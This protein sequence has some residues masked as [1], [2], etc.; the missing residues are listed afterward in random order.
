MFEW[1]L[2]GI[3]LTGFYAFQVLIFKTPFQV[4][5]FINEKARD[6]RLDQI[7]GFAMIGIVMIHIHSYFYFFHPNEPNVTNWTLFLS[8]LS[9]FSVPVFVFGSSL[10]LKIKPGY[11]KTKFTGLVLPYTLASAIGYLI[12]YKDWA[13]LDFTLKLLTGQVFAPYYFVPL[14]FQFYILF[15]ILPSFLKEGKWLTITV[16]LSLFLNFLSNINI[17]NGIL[18][19]WYGP[20]SI[21]NYLGFFGLGLLLKQ[22][23]IS[24]KYLPSN[25]FQ[26]F[27]I[28]IVLSISVLILGSF[29][30][31]GIEMKNHHLFYPIATVII[32]HSL[33]SNDKNVFFVRLISFIGKNS[34]FIFLIHPFVIHTMHSWDPYSFGGPILGYLITLF[35]NLS[36]PGLFALII[37]NLQQRFSNR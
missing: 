12:K 29:S 14:L 25:R 15:F 32:L 37:K 27:S 5:N 33:L 1:E 22:G 19:S 34:L 23:S 3:V 28:S 8:N 6:T 20:I 11:W 30:F 2:F 17:L 4:P 10:Y 9:R 21:F 7:R 31:N 35:L 16:V 24:P 26:I 36:I 13:L 18:P